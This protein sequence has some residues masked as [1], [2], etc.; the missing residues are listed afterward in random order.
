MKI[1]DKE[2]EEAIK[3]IDQKVEDWLKIEPTNNPEDIALMW[4]EEAEQYIQ[5]YMPGFEKIQ[6]YLEDLDK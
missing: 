4:G 1:I 2:L 3:Y 6:K 5:N